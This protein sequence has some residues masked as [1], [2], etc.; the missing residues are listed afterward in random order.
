MAETAPD[1]GKNEG[2]CPL[3]LSK[4]LRGIWP[5]KEVV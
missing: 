2:M 3:M 5:L 4:E 1:L